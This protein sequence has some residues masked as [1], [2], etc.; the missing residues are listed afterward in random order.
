MGAARSS[1]ES[2]MMLSQR[3]KPFMV[4]SRRTTLAFL[5][6]VLIGVKGGVD[7]VAF[8]EGIA[9][10]GEIFVLEVFDLGG[11]A[12]WGEDAEFVVAVGHGGE[13]NGGE[14]AGGEG[15]VGDG[16]LAVGFPDFGVA[17]GAAIDADIQLAQAGVVGEEDLARG[18]GGAQEDDA[19][20]RRECRDNADF[21]HADLASGV[22][23]DVSVEANV[24][25]YGGGLAVRAQGRRWQS[26]A[27]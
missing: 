11:G 26:S 14:R 15:P 24:F 6:S 25:R 19:E 10:P 20:G 17:G 21:F 23:Q 5:P 3:P 8:A 16:G 4:Y 1:L 22:H 27:T 18:A 7:G 9:E 2:L 12:V 13:G